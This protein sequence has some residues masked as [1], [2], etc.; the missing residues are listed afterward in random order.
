[1]RSVGR[2]YARLLERSERK[3]VK[4]NYPQREID[5]NLMLDFSELIMERNVERSPSS[6]FVEFINLINFLS[7]A[8]IL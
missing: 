6:A 2:P 4:L 7:S 3:K 8:R 5:V 1:M